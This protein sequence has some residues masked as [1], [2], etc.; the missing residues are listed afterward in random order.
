MSK[1]QYKK[2]E[3]DV[4][5]GQN[6]PSYVENQPAYSGYTSLP[7]PEY[8]PP[9]DP[10]YNQGLLIQPAQ[11]LNVIRFQ[12]TKEPDYLAYSIFTM[13]CCCLPL[14]IAALVYSVQ[15]QEANRTGNGDSARR[16]SKL[17]RNLSHIAFGVGLGSLILYIIF[18]IFLYN[19]SVS[20]MIDSPYTVSP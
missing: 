11:A 2:I 19:Q 1:P 17:A 18:V 8:Q 16:N 4:P 13:L 6:P 14:G 7:P 10:R 9:Y 12:P 20:Q 5:E 15:T 3:E